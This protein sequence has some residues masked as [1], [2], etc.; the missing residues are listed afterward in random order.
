MTKIISHKGLEKFHVYFDATN[1]N[2]DYPTYVKNVLCDIFLEDN[3]AVY[4]QFENVIKNNIGVSLKD[5]IIKAL[6]YGKDSKDLIKHIKK[7]RAKTD[8]ALKEKIFKAIKVETPQ[9]YR[10][11][12]KDLCDIYE[13]HTNPVGQIINWLQNKDNYKEC[14]KANKS[15]YKSGF[16]SFATALFGFYQANTWL[17]TKQNDLLFCQLIAENTLFASREVFELVKEGELG[18]DA[19][20][21]DKKG[22]KV[23]GKN[24][25][26]SW[27]YMAHARRVK[28]NKNTLFTDPDN[29][30]I[31]KKLKKMYKEINDNIITDDN[32]C[33][34]SYI[35]TAILESYKRKFKDNSL[36][37]L[38][39]KDF[40]VDYEA[41][42]VWDLP[43]DRRYYASIG[44]LVL[45]PRALAQLTDHCDA[46]KQ[47]LR[48]E[49]WIRF[50]FKPEEEKND[51]QI[52]DNLYKQIHWRDEYG[53]EYYDKD[54]GKF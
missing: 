49:V 48:Y 38:G 13:E 18:A 2:K 26:G 44:N 31:T 51:P 5:K 11:K 25:Y 8:E 41:C 36:F 7:M 30:T 32:S 52:D 14:K 4:K 6:D 9:I 23:R 20:K 50:G 22:I 37:E 27:D 45:V 33:A 35:K 47:L 43:G 3:D 21:K 34:N 12:Y 28:E 46:V 40:F 1:P 39:T 42:H 16:K 10:S 53:E 54:T 29:N 15:S 24:E 19:L 17:R